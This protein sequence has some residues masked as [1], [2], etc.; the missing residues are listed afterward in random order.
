MEKVTTSNSINNGVATKV[1]EIDGLKVVLVDIDENIQN[2]GLSLLINRYV[3]PQNFLDIVESQSIQNAIR[4][5]GGNLEAHST[6]DK[7]QGDTDQRAECE[8]CNYQSCDVGMVIMPSNKRKKKYFA[9]MPVMC[10]IK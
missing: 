6:R 3:S 10:I 8:N 7:T 9:F 2:S 4:N 1:V 5:A